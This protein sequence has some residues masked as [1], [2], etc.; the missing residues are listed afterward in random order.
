VKT[1]RRRWAAVRIV[2]AVAVAVAA[3]LA[4]SVPAAHA[5]EYVT[6]EWGTYNGASTFW[7]NLAVGG[8]YG[9]C[10]D[11]GT[12]PPDSLGDQNAT[13]VCG[14]TSGSTPDKTT[15]IAFLLARHLR[16][17][18]T[19]TLVSLSQFARA[20]YH[21]GIPVTYPARFNELVAEAKKAGPRDAYA[22]VDLAASK[23][24]FGLVRQGQAAQITSGAL[25]R[26]GADYLAGHR[27][28]V[29]ITT[30]NATFT[31]GSKT[32]TVDTTGSAGS[33][34]LVTTHDLIA[35]EQVSV[36]V[37]VTGVPQAC[38]MVHQETGTQR[39]L[40][41]LFTDLSGRHTATQD[42]TIWEPRVAT[43]VT[44]PT[45]QPSGTVTDRVRAEAVNGSQWPVKEWADAN[46]TIPKTYHSFTA[47]G[48]IV[49]AATPQAASKTLPE[50]AVVLPG[51]V[52]ATLT[53]PGVWAT[54]PV[55]LPATA[56]SGYYSLRWCLD[57]AAQG[58]NAKFL[59]DGGPWCDDYFSTTER[60]TVPMTL[61][62]STKAPDRT[63]A[64]G[65]PADDTVTV[66]L[67]NAA[68][69]WIAGT[70][71]SPVTVKAHGTLYG[72]STPPI[73]Q[74]TVPA[75]AVRLGEA[76][77][78]VVLPT[79]GREPV[80]VAA[81][82]GFDLR[83]ST[84]W[85]W[86][87]EVR[88]ADQTAPVAALL[89]GAVKDSYGRAD[90]SGLAPMTV[91]VASRLPDQHRAKG[92]APDDVITVSLPNQADQWIALRSGKP[93]VVRV[94]GVYYAGSRSS[95][96][97]SDQPPPDAKPLG[98]AS[99]S[100]TLP[101]SG[102]S[103]VTVAAPAGFTVPSSQYGTWVWRIDRNKQAP[104]V[105]ELFDNDPADK[106]GQ[107]LETHV[108]QMELTIQSQ[109]AEPTV[110]EPK[111]DA[112]AQV[113]DTVWVE[114]TSPDDLWLNQWGTDKP[115]EVNVGGKL[116]RSAVPGPQTTA[117][118]PDVP[119]V[120]EYEL[121]FTAAGE[122]HAQKVCHT[123]AYGDYGAYGFVFSIDPDDQPDAT[124]E[125]LSK[126]AATPLWL[127]VETT[128][129]RR[130]PVIHTAATRWAATNNGEQQVFFT[131]EVWQIDW[132]D[133]QDDTDLHGAV[134]HTD[135]AGYGPWQPDQGTITTELWRVEG[136]VTPESCAA[137][138]PDAKLIAVNRATPA[139]NTWGGSHKVSGSRFKAEGGDATY[140]FVISYPGDARTEPYKSVCG[141]ESETITLI[142]QAPEFITQLLSPADLEAATPAAAAEREAAIEVEP[143]SELVD[144]LHAWFPDTDQ[145]PSDM[146][147]WAATWDTH[148]VPLPAD[149]EP[150][151]VVDSDAGRVYQGAVCTP[152][153]LLTSSGEPVPVEGAGDH[154]S[155]VFTVPDEPGMVFTVETVTNG[156]GQVVRRGT[157]GAV[158]ESAVV[159]SPPAPE[160]TTNAPQ[161]A[162]VGES[163]RDEALLTGP[164]P[165]GTV[166]EFWYQHTPYA[167]PGAPADDL[168]CD[169]PDPADM[170]GAVKIGVTVLDHD[171]PE[172]ATDKLHSPEFTN[173]REGCT[174]IKETAYEPG[175][176]TDK[177][178]IAEGRFDALNERTMW[179]QP[180]ASTPPD[181]DLPLT[182]ANA[183]RIGMAGAVLVCAGTGLLAAARL[184]QRRAARTGRVR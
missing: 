13:R 160:I 36:S 150:L 38:F 71:G 87:W 110:P 48:R 32:R 11:P 83:G 9:L 47:T 69:Q 19:Q 135:W 14:S 127:P 26:T 133:S 149:A 164:Y 122:E 180:P 125:Y 86:V 3:G 6:G 119:V 80:T 145:Q 151:P 96:V 137:D 143:G 62:M 170:D 44:T 23:V 128:M 52:T 142:H 25:G 41:P 101:T 130:V 104:E 55:V 167:N 115:V 99:V 158:S 120:D 153:T 100:V 15:Q 70:D 65:R 51:E 159:L 177:T 88:L 28:T 184:R 42:K 106:F 75:G 74:P 60:F 131:D 43:E 4:V 176:G 154:R 132:P 173:D 169:P 139:V 155:P 172:D 148:F 22:E 111:G 136:E 93:A 121:V 2:T 141:E 16:D 129:V 30:P 67:P 63:V 109:V 97:I 72:S 95:F 183:A 5:A 166:V 171:I 82:A 59:P 123:V 165:K 112:T 105:A 116:Y 39:V 175:D 79:S 1:R 46:Q 144:V 12:E 179:H 91:A 113:C 34:G 76:S 147:G 27:V 156:E 94:D 124:K 24:W 73:E 37:A 157:C 58:T 45:V 134:G 182:G 181:Q 64:K 85:T 29:T 31:D 35:D 146:T 92:Q 163:I 20:E 118:D 138:N 103:P 98:S 77:V 50:G 174:W 81:P 78:D 68:D 102:R 33:L 162:N 49:R 117:I 7:G 114:H 61:G 40:T 66:Y 53:G 107:P 56:G 54:A 90:E 108:T 168:T 126:G 89:N 178:V 18:D 140:T 17:T 161:H 8:V 10:I 84:H 21:S 152:E 57:R